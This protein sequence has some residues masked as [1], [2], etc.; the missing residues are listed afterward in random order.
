[1]IVY[2]RALVCIPRAAQVIF[3]IPSGVFCTSAVFIYCCLSVGFVLV[4]HS[5]LH[6]CRYQRAVLLT[7]RGLLTHQLGSYNTKLVSYLVYSLVY[8]LL[9]RKR[10]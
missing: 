6:V 8:G 4:C 1:M 7:L 5:Y 10:L 3:F 9:L 2:I